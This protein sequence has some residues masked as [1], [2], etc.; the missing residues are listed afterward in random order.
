MR[1]R[2]VSAV[3]ALARWPNALLSASGVVFGAWWA[4]WGELGAGAVRPVSLAA[5]GAI[6]L[7]VT[8]NVWNDLADIDVDRRAHPARALPSGRVSLAAAR[9]IAAVAAIAGVALTAGSA[10]ALGV[11]S[12]AVVALMYAYSPWLKRAGVVGN[13]TVAVLASLPFLYGGWAVG[14]PEAALMLVGIAAPLHLAREIAKDLED[15]P[16]DAG[17]RRTLPITAGTSAAL[18]LLA[19]AALVFLLLLLPFA[20]ARPRFAAAALPAAA[21]VIY[22]VSTAMRGHRGSPLVFK[23]AMVCAMAAFLVARP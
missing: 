5:L 17:A 21:L 4:G 15:A 13:C 16:A 20:T 7:T 3:L 6:A 22:A 11:V 1:A 9:R 8:A 2:S 12:V 10:P 23:L 19:V 18:A 14:R